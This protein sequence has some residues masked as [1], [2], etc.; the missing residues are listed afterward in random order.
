MQ[1]CSRGRKKRNKLVTSRQKYH[2]TLL[3]KRHVPHG[4]ALYPHV[5]GVTIKRFLIRTLSYSMAA[6]AIMEDLHHCNVCLAAFEHGRTG[7]QLALS[8]LRRSRCE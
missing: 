5:H 3:C 1:Q 6:L 2:A 7:N 4:R 8:E